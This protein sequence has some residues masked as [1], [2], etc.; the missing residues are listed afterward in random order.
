MHDA[1]S[2]IH[3]YLNNT[4][5]GQKAPRA[6]FFSKQQISGLRQKSNI[7]PPSPIFTVQHTNSDKFFVGAT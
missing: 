1:D 6:Q 2:F 5:V 7:Q 4:R 3:A